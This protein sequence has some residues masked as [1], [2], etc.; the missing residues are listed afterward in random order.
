MKQVHVYR[1]ADRGVFIKKQ[2]I[3][4]KNEKKKNNRIQGN[5]K[6]GIAIEN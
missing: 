3:I 1:F 6:I 2:L 5:K 4:L